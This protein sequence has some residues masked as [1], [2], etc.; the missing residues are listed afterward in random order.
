MRNSHIH[1]SKHSHSPRDCS[2][3]VTQASQITF[4]EG[5]NPIQARQNTRPIGFADQPFPRDV[6]RNCKANW[7]DRSTLRPQRKLMCQFVN[8]ACLVLCTGPNTLSSH[9][10]ACVLRTQ[11]CLR[12][13]LRIATT[14][15]C[16][17]W[18]P[19]ILR[20]TG[21]ALCVH[22]GSHAKAAQ[23]DEHNDKRWAADMQPIGNG[24]EATE[25]NNIRQ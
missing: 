22:T 21:L 2:L 15:A 8:L 6:K 24:V 10:R 18:Q 16:N 19:T 25:R 12:M 13:R 7:F 17:V 11:A 20:D 1:K 4:S 9:I 14:T 23:F 3:Q 5:A